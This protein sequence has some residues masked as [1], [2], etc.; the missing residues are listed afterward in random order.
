MADV[1][2]RVADAPVDNLF[3]KR[4]S[5]LAFSK[6]PVTDSQ[7][8]SI[9]E[10]ARWSP[11]SY[12]EQPWLFVYANTPESLEKLR[13]LLVDGNRTWADTAP[14]LLFVFAKKRF[15]KNDKPNSCAHF[16]CGSATMSLIL[17]AEKLGLKA[18]A[19][20]G[21]HVDKAYEKLG[22]SKEDF[23]AV[24]AVA[25]GEYGNIAEYP[26]D[27][28]SRESSVSSRNQVSTFAHLGS[29]KPA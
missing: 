12:N 11:S 23:D 24:C 9:F 28:Q 18:H 29:F 8:A 27:L 17:Q 15:A 20:A 2:S 3:I 26:E 19:M 4:W 25:I 1:D 10:A 13:P 22:V 7:V 21:F 16:D 14:M 5:P 6:T